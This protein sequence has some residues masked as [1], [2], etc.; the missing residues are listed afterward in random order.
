MADIKAAAESIIAAYASA[1]AKG[2]DLSTPLSEVASAMAKCYLP[3]WT[4]F[5]LGRII[6]FKDEE[7]TQTAIH[8]QLTRFQSM[9]LGT[10]IRLG[11]SEVEP[12]SDSSAICWITWV[13]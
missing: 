2:S 1:M 4:S 8:H 5:T 10:N 12:I 13:V 7:A 3:G 6:P 9:G 11:N